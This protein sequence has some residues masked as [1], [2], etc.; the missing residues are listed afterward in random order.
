[1][2]ICIYNHSCLTWLSVR[3]LLFLCVCVYGCVYVCMDECMC[4]CT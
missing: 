1:M 4:V 3:D 2:K